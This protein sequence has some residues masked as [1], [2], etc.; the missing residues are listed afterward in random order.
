MVTLTV[1]EK[2]YRLDPVTAA[3]TVDADLTADLTTGRPPRTVPGCWC[4][5]C[6]PAPPP[7][8]GRSRW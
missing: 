3:V 4:A 8:P 5:G 2:A 1:T 6:S 7:T